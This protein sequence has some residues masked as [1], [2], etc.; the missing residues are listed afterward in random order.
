MSRAASGSTDPVKAVSVISTGAVR[1]HPQ[2]RYGTPFPLYWWLLTSRRWTPPLPI[3]VYVIE[4]ARGLIVFDT[5]QD[6]AS[7]TDTGYFPAGPVGYLYHR[8]ARFTIGEDDT[9]TSQLATLGYTPA[10]I[11]TAIV[12]HL[13]EDHIGGLRELAGSSLV[14]SAAEWGELT[15]PAPEL[16]GFLRRHI[17]L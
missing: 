17:W 2:Q 1:I 9:L 15:G 16:R 6:R 5:G 7:I 13:H 3:N 14:V 12:S 10:D 8:L 11:D 4:H